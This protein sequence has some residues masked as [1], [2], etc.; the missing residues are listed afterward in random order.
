MSEVEA[1]KARIADLEDAIEPLL[2]YAMC[3]NYKLEGMFAKTP[4]GQRKFE[5]FQRRTIYC[6]LGIFQRLQYLYDLKG[7][8]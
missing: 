2:P 4:E 1:L 6:D 3:D 7:K 5:D 8:Y